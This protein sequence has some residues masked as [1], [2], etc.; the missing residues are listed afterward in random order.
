MTMGPPDDQDRR[1]DIGAA[2]ALMHAYRSHFTCAD[3]QMHA[4]RSHT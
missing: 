2:S 4:Y 3:P 1:M